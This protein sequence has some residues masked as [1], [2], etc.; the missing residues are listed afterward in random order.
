LYVVALAIVPEI[1]VMTLK[2]MD[3]SSHSA[4]LKFALNFW[5]FRSKQQI[6]VYN[7]K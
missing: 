5:V 4:V 3:L 7:K 2:A 1:A 6:I